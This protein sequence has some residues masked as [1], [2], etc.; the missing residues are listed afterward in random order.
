MAPCILFFDE[1]DTL[2]AQRELQ[3]PISIVNQLLT[4]MDGISGEKKN[5]VILGATTMPWR[6]DRAL[7]RGG[8][9]DKMMY[10]K[11][12]DFRT[13]VEAF[14]IFLRKHELVSPNIDLKELALLTEYYS[15][16]DIKTVVDQAAVY[17]LEQSLKSGE[18][19]QKIEQWHLIDAIRER[20]SSLI[21][22]FK[23]AGKRIVEEGAKEDYPELWNDVLRFSAASKRKQEGSLNE[24]QLRRM[25]EEWRR[26]DETV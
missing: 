24:D 23:F 5:V 12:P 6:L 2:G 13:R 18:E 26:Q 20:K 11:P 9:L 21:S 15:T 14:R 4:E 1:L 10:V 3:G 16:A 7:L 22:W 19:K 17:V 25:K 8:R